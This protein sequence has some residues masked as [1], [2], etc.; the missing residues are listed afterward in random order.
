MGLMAWIILSGTSRGIFDEGPNG[1]KNLAIAI[2]SIAIGYCW[3]KYSRYKK[4]KK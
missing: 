4:N 3:A 2:I 1:G